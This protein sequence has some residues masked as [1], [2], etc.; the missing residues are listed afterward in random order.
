MKKIN[1]DVMETWL[2]FRKI[3]RNDKDFSDMLLRQLKEYEITPA[4]IMRFDGII[5]VS[6]IS[7][8]SL[9]AECIECLDDLGKFDADAWKGSAESKDMSIL[10]NK[11]ISEK[12]NLDADELLGKARFISDDVFDGLLSSVSR[13]TA[14]HMVR[15]YRGDHCTLDMAI[16]YLDELG[17]AIVAVR[18]VR[19]DLANDD[20]KLVA[21]IIQ[22][23]KALDPLVAIGIMHASYTPAEC[24]DLT[25]KDADDDT[26]KSMGFDTAEKYREMLDDII[27]RYPADVSS[28][29]MVSLSMHASPIITDRKLIR[30]WLIFCDGIAEQDLLS[31]MPIACQVGLRDEVIAYAKNYGYRDLLVAMAIKN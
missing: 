20:S 13:E 3:I 27:Q 31:V 9:S 26:L 16:D 19:Q 21:K 1:D 2:E 18:C 28:N 10:L 30:D 11:D 24:A 17:G 7:G 8:F 6:K 23:G 22:S 25:L 29:L 14:A 15:V 5:D 4:F 12:Y